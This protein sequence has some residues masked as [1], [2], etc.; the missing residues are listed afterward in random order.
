VRCGR[1]YPLLA[2]KGGTYA[3]LAGVAALAGLKKLVKERKVSQNDRVLAIISGSGL[4]DSNS[5]LSL[6]K[7]L[8]GGI[9]ALLGAMGKKTSA[10]PNCLTS[11]NK[12]D[13]FSEGYRKRR[14]YKKE[15]EHLG[16]IVTGSNST[17]AQ[18]GIAKNRTIRIITI[19]W[20]NFFLFILPILSFSPQHG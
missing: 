12:W 14:L 9:G 7:E 8:K 3:E 18:T 17:K 19:F 16:Q 11:D 1:I 2:L 13:F 10:S 4:K 15:V 20:E 6:S 5:S